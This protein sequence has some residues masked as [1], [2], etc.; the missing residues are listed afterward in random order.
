MQKKSLTNNG[1]VKVGVNPT[2]GLVITQNSNKPEYGSIRL[3]YKT[4]K[5]NGGFT[6]N[7]NRSAFIHGKI[8]DLEA[9]GLTEGQEL[10]GKII[11][12]DS[13][14]PLYPNHQPKINPQTNEVVLTDGKPTYFEFIYT[15]EANAQDIWVDEVEVGVSVET[16]AEQAL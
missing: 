7:G 3:D 5:L 2:T 8:V 6:S 14:S 4:A 1:V 9:Y 15:E 12:K 16:I 13:F 11:K 10:V